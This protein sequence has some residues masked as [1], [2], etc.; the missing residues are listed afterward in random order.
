MHVKQHDLEV[1]NVKMDVD[2]VA[3]FGLIKNKKLN[4]MLNIMHKEV[5]MATVPGKMELHEEDVLVLV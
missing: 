3:N 4:Y 1:V 2:Q 5:E